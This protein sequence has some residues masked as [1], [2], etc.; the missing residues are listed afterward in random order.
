MTELENYVA[1]EWHNIAGRGDVAVIDTTGRKDVSV[2]DGIIIDSY[3][4]KIRGIERMGSN[5]RIGILIKGKKN[6]M[7]AWYYLHKNNP[8]KFRHKWKEGELICYMRTATYR[9]Y[10]ARLSSFKQVN[11]ETLRVIK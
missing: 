3:E 2:G 1:E 6:I 5:P 8:K 4:Y 10:T 11:P 7:N 9:E